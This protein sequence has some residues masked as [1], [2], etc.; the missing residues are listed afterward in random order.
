MRLVNL[1]SPV[2]VDD[3]YENAEHKGNGHRY[4]QPTS[5][6]G[7]KKNLGRD[8]KKRGYRTKK[9]RATG[10]G[11][12]PMVG[13]YSR[14]TRQ[15]IIQ[16]TPSLKRKDVEVLFEM[17]VAPGSDVFTDEQTTYWFVG[18]S[19]NHSVV[20]HSTKQWVNGDAHTNSVECQWSFWRSFSRPHRGFSTEHLAAWSAWFTLLRNYRDKGGDWLKLTYSLILSV[21]GGLLRKLQAQG[22]LAAVY[23][24]LRCQGS[25]ST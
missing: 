21:P 23:P 19:Y 25:V 15:C 5:K 8:P 7:R 13:M 12:E 2:E 14:A 17:N 18:D 9:G 4:D 6:H 16:P 22:L 20:E 11:R 10:A 3:A 1:I 24:L